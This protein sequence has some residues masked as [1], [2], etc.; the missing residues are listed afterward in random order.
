MI[1]PNDYWVSLNSE[2]G[3]IT[4][5]AAGKDLRIKATRRRVHVK[6]K[7][8]SVQFYSGGGKVW[9]IVVVAPKAGE[10]IALVEYE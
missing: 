8:T 4:L 5:S 10:W 7:V 3:E 9:S 6:S 1:P 2:A